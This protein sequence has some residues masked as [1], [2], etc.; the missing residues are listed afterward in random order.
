MKILFS[1][2]GKVIMFS[3]LFSLFLPSLA[4]GAETTKDPSD[5]PPFQGPEY[6]LDTSNAPLWDC[7]GLRMYS[8]KYSKYCEEVFQKCSSD[9]QKEGETTLKLFQENWLEQEKICLLINDSIREEKDIFSLFERFNLLGREA[10]KIVNKLM[11]LDLKCRDGKK[12]PN[13]SSD[14][15]NYMDSG[16]TSNNPSSEQ[17][18]SW[19]N[20][21][22]SALF[23]WDSTSW[24]GMKQQA[25]DYWQSKSQATDSPL[26]YFYD[27]MAGLAGAG[28]KTNLAL[29]ALSILPLAS[30]SKL[31]TMGNLGPKLTMDIIN[32]SLSNIAVVFK[33]LPSGLAGIAGIGNGVN[34]TQAGTVAIKQALAG[35]PIAN[36]IAKHEIAH[37]L[38][39]SE[40]QAWKITSQA[41]SALSLGEKIKSLGT[42]AGVNTSFYWLL[43]K[44]LPTFNNTL[45]QAQYLFTKG[46]TKNIWRG[47]K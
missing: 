18:S 29:L 17:P 27:L 31:F 40:V 4:W 13:D 21:T 44:T 10:S 46:I 22:A 16:G 12:Q 41:F 5:L 28:S 20:D 15:F 14:D 42:L 47:Y 2:T 8:E 33:N 36:V 45:L 3:I 32:S 38:G 9:I 19:I 1:T 7:D 30:L 39:A 6:E 35:N 34:F 26:Q 37:L 11:Q 25:V 24:E 43:S 23:S